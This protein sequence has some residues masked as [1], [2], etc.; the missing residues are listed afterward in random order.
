MPKKRDK[1]DEV[2]TVEIKRGDIIIPNVVSA[3]RGTGGNIVLESGDGKTY[4][5]FPTF[6]AILT[7]R[8]PA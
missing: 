2:E 4:V 5:V 1:W 8:P 7:P 6:V 3:D